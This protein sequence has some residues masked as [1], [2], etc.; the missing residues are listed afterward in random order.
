[1]ANLSFILLAAP[2]A[3]TGLSVPAAASDDDGESR[4]AIVRYGD[5]NLSTDEGRETLTS[6]VKFAVRQV[7]GS[8]PHYRQT[9][10]ERGRAILCERSAMADAEVKLATLFNGEGTRLADAGPLVI[11]AAP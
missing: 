8:R 1:M 6:R 3:L 11:A 10:A 2:M 4:T 9:L 5:L 7:C